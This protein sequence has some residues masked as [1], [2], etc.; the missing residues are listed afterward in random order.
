MDGTTAEASISTIG[1]PPDQGMGLYCS[2]PPNSFPSYLEEHFNSLWW[3][4]WFA[5]IAFPMSFIT[6]LFFLLQPHWPSCCYSNT[7]NMFVPQSSV[8]ATLLITNTQAPV[9]H[10]A[11]LSSTKT[12][13]QTSFSEKSLPWPEVFLHSNTIA[14]FSSHA[15]LFFLVLS[16]TW[17]Y[18]FIC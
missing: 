11:H 17:H 10:M 14:L 16:T 2:Q 8:L 4:P 18:I 12:P 7:S 15:L 9:L 1:W 13:T 6:V 3:P 5:L